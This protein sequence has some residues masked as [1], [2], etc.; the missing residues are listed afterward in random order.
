[1]GKSAPSPPAAPDPK[2]TAAAQAAANKEA[3][4]ASA[5]IGMINQYTPGGTL[6]YSQRGTA[7]DGTPQYSATQTLSPEQQAIYDQQT[8]AATKYGQTA[9]A[10]LS[11]VSDLLSQPLDYSGLG[12]APVLNE[13]TRTNVANS[14]YERMN[15]QFD[16]DRQALETQLANQGFMAGTE[17]YNTAIDELN[18]ARNDARL[19]IEANALG[20][21]SQLY[22]IEA[23]QRDRAINELV[24]QRQVPLNEL[25]AMM[26]GTQVQG[27]QFV[28]TPQQQIQ[29]TDIMG[30]TYGSANLAN[31]NYAQQVA[32]QNAG[33]QGLYG[34]LGSGAM[35]AAYLWSDRRLKTGIRK[36][37]ELP[38]GLSLYLYRYLWGGPLQLGVMAQDAAKMFPDAVKEFN[39]YLAVN[40][41]RIS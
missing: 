25:A 34:L 33:T 16:R 24:Q 17:G 18:R 19:G 2:E 1:M 6:E 32:A 28:N 37:A 27:P 41:A 15:P 14:L 7:A 10:Q 8:Q 36:V 21:A 38:S 4:I 20:Q 11:S 23:N 3:A 30:A 13:E 39:G 35:A 9:N 22:G 5:N 29:P 12:Q 26:T 40:Y 31:Q